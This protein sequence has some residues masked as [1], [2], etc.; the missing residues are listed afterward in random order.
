MQ[1][2]GLA[3][4]CICAIYDEKSR[5]H[6]LWYLFL[7]CPWRWHKAQHQDAH[8][9][10]TGTSR[11]RTACCLE[12]AGWRQA[13]VW[14]DEGGGEHRLRSATAAPAQSVTLSQ[15]TR[16]FAS[17]GKNSA[18]SEKAVKIFSTIA[19]F[20]SMIL[21]FQCHVQYILSVIKVNLNRCLTW[22]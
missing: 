15:I 12:P 7:L 20:V 11:A 17:T 22:P 16:T 18:I 14:L 10:I 19:Q 4:L 21:C 3:Q 8:I 5:G 2:M 6:F 9:T 1:L 13:L